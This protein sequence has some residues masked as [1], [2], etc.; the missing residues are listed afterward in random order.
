MGSTL[1]KYLQKFANLKIE[2]DQDLW[3]ASTFFRAPHKP[4]LLMSIIDLVAHGSLT[5]NFVEPSFELIE[6]FN[7][8]WAAITTMLPD[9]KLAESFLNLEEEGFWRAK[10]VQGK[11]FTGPVDKLKK[12]QDNYMGADLAK[13]LF[14]LL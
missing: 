10:P 13:S 6:T 3:P 14:S 1:D 9:C 4:L 7:S 11:K 12:L 8:Y 5:K 2:E